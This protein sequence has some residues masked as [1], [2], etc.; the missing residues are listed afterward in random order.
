MIIDKVIAEFG[1]KSVCLDPHFEL[2]LDG[3]LDVPKIEARGERKFG[4]TGTGVPFM[5]AMLEMAMDAF[6]E[7]ITAL[8]SKSW[9]EARFLASFSNGLHAL[10]T[11]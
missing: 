9:T 6:L 4:S 8:I 3:T 5:A 11:R 1:N 10:T 2:F 7:A